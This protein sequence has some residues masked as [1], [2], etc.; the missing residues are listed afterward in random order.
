[1]RDEIYTDRKDILKWSVVADATTALCGRL[2]A[3]PNAA[4]GRRAVVE[5]ILKALPLQ[6][7]DPQKVSIEYVAMFTTRTDKTNEEPILGAH[8]AVSRFFADEQAYIGPRNAKQLTRISSLSQ[9]LGLSMTFC[10]RPKDAELF[11][12]GCAPNQ[13]VL[14]ESVNNGAYRVQYFDAVT[15][16]LKKRDDPALSIVFVDPDTG[17]GEGQPHEVH[18]RQCALKQIC[19]ALRPG[20]ALAVYQHQQ[21][22]TYPNW[23]SSNRKIVA[24]AMGV[25]LDHVFAFGPDNEGSIDMNVNDACIYLVQK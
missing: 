13:L 16:S 5:A 14:H 1:M 23:V 10:P 18:V 17:I 8:P 3:D 19:Q 11:H 21:N 22:Q 7:P 25:T 12:L 24:D 6:A 9:Q 20:D 15:T 4:T 2:R